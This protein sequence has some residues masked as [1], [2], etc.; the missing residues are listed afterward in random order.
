MTLGLE[1]PF[2]GGVDWA[3]H[4]VALKKAN[5]L[6][7]CPPEPAG[8]GGVRLR[9][10]PLL[11]STHPNWLLP[12]FPLWHPKTPDPPAHARSWGSASLFPSSN[13]ARSSE[14]P[15]WDPGDLLRPPPG[16]RLLPILSGVT[17]DRLFFSRGTAEGHRTCA[18]G[19][20][21]TGPLGSA[22]PYL[23]RPTAPCSQW[24]QE[25]TPSCAQGRGVRGLLSRLGSAPWL[26][27]EH[28]WVLS[29]P[30]FPV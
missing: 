29:V 30:Q 20:G 19:L 23:C 27:I 14:S 8:P 15:G 11:L 25:Q 12:Q 10:W 2:H 1:R 7:R 16:G 3:H 17:P 18:Q 6:A 13:G 21:D 28:V 26:S 4:G 24:G 5:V 9:L 22:L